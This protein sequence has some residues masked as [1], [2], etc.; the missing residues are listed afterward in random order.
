MLVGADGHKAWRKTGPEGSAVVTWVTDSESH[1][2]VWVRRDPKAHP[3]PGT[4][5]EEDS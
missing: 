2:I 5:S 1:G 4:G 3:V